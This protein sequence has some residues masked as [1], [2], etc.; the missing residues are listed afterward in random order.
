MLIC[1]PRCSSCLGLDSQIAAPV[2]LQGKISQ[3]PLHL[4]TLYSSETLRLI[5]SRTIS[6]GCLPP[7]LYVIPHALLCPTNTP[8]A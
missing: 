1:F 3:C 2:A 7:T 5:S 8:L 4:L 6:L